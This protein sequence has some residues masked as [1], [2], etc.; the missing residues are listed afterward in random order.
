M[1]GKT[2]LLIEDEPDI[3]LIVSATLKAN[4]YN[5]ISVLN[6]EEG[7]KM[8]SLENPDLILLDV[9]MPGMDGYETLQELKQKEDTKNIPTVF[10]SAHIQISEIQKGLKLGAKGYIKKPFDPMTLHKEVAQ[11]FNPEIQENN[12]KGPNEFI[13]DKKLVAEYTI[14]LKKKV[15][16]L[17]NLIEYKDFGEAAKLAHKIAGS[18]G[19]YGFTEFSSTALNIE[20]KCKTG[21]TRELNN[22]ILELE[23]E[24]KLL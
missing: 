12:T 13:L 6:G 14:G 23:N 16:Q 24:K 9:S 3:N 1:N 7:I 8:A 15:H 5:I 21:E 4:G 10:F 22:L 2:I 17:K 11:Y 18:A 20:T 19:S